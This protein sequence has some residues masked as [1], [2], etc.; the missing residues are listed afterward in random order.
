[1]F[2]YLMKWNGMECRKVSFFVS[3]KFLRTISS[4]ICHEGLFQDEILKGENKLPIYCRGLS[5]SWGVFL[6]RCLAAFLL[7]SSR[8]CFSATNN[9]GKKHFSGIIAL[10]VSNTRRVKKRFR[11]HK[12]FIFCAVLNIIFASLLWAREKGVK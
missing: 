9:R 7:L 2:I 5:T 6:F 3:M 1:M 12:I 8:V 10:D 4:E 11:D